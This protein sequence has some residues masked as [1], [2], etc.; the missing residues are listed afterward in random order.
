M[1]ILEVLKAPNPILTKKSIEVESVDDELRAF[2]DDMLETM[3]HD[4][5]VGIAAPQVGV[6]KRIFVLDLGSDD[7][8][9]R[10]KGFYPKFIVNPQIEYSFGESVKAMEGCLSVPRQRIEVERM[11]GVLLKY[12]DYH[13][14]KCEIK[15]TGWM[16]RAIQHELD[17]LDG[18]LL[19][20]YLSPLKKT[21]IMNKL[22]KVK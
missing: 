12:L 3:Y 10:E 21:M 2:M 7:N 14:K 6:L 15:T 8:I 16:S 20:D 11:D 19:I 4:G 22:R 1:A 9:A 5:G 18:K 13:G 17:H